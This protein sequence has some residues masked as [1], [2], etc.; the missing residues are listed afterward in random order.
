MAGQEEVES[1]VSCDGRQVGLCGE[2]KQRSLPSLLNFSEN[3]TG[4]TQLLE[5]PTSTTRAIM[6]SG[7]KH[8]YVDPA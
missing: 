6:A 7:G 3:A 1:N 2:K 8:W 5:Q 4:R